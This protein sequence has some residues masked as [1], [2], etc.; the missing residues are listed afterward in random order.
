MQSFTHTCTNFKIEFDATRSETAAKLQQLSKL[1]KQ[2]SEDEDADPN[3]QPKHRYHLR[4]VCTHYKN[5]YVY[6]RSEL[7]PSDGDWWKFEYTNNP[8]LTRLV[9]VPLF[10]SIFLLEFLN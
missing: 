1:L 6:K 4:G 8:S 3:L 9:S 5:V 7:D 10:H 2:P